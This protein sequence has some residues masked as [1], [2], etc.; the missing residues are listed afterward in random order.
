V[1]ETSL[2]QPVI[3]MAL[4]QTS[5]DPLPRECEQRPP[6]EVSIHNDELAAMLAREKSMPLGLALFGG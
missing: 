2:R 1:L 5:F 3:V 4:A 6:C